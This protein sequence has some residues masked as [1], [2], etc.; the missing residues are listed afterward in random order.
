[1]EITNCDIRSEAAADSF[2]YQCTNNSETRYKQAGKHNDWKLN[3]I[4][5]YY[6]LKKKMS[7]ENNSSKQKKRQTSGIHPYRRVE[8]M[9]GTS[10]ALIQPI[11]Q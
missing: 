1:M 3:S 2:K 8:Q 9:P 7:I 5:S 4:A 10:T 6:T 11:I